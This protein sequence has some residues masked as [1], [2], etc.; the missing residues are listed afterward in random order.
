[1]EISPRIVFGGAI[2]KRECSANIPIAFV[3][4]W[5]RGAP[6]TKIPEFWQFHNPFLIFN[7]AF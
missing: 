1:M 5:E 3:A 6:T 4:I 2:A 7:F